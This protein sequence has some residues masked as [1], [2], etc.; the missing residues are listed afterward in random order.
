MRNLIAAPALRAASAATFVLALA[1]LIPPAAFAGHGNGTPEVAATPVSGNIACPSSA[2][3]VGATLDGPAFTSQ[4]G[5]WNGSEY[6]IT[7]TPTSSIAGDIAEITFAIMT[8]SGPTVGARE[9]HLKH[10]G[11]SNLYDYNVPS[12]GFYPGIEHDDMLA[13]PAG[14]GATHL[15]FCLVQLASIGTPV[16]LRSFRAVRGRSCVRLLWRTASELDFLGFNVYRQIRGRRVRLNR[17]LIVA[18]SLMGRGIT[19]G[20]Y[21]W[22]DRPANG[23]RIPR[24]AKYLLQAVH[25]DG[26]KT[27]FRPVRTQL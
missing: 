25:L 19:G 12:A 7:V 1:A 10:A 9:V 5:S 27:L 24:T 15:T 16:E 14:N 13:N 6:T 3:E 11:D 23:K 18:K 17:T 2:P 22:R 20:T 21:S 4:Q 8:M 26:T